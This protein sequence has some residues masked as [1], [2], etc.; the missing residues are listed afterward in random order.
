MTIPKLLF[1]LLLTFNV[2]NPGLALVALGVAG[3]ESIRSRVEQRMAAARLAW[4]RVVRRLHRS[5][6][7]ELERS[8]ALS[9][10]HFEVE[11]REREWNRE[12]RHDGSLL[13]W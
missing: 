9:L 4:M 2:T 6:R 3:C 7:G 10:D 1:E 5:R 12:Y 8:L 13:G 11:R